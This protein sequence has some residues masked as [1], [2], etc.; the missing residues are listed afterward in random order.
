MADLGPWLITAR[1]AEHA[2]YL[3]R[4]RAEQ[5][6]LH[7]TSVEVSDGGGDMWSVTVVVEEPDDVARAAQLN[8]DTQV[9]HLGTHRPPQ[10]GDRRE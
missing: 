6:G 8:D 9:L 3:I 10:G 7:V 4:S 1:S 5:R 2:D